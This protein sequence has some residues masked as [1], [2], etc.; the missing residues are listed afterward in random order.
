MSPDQNGQTDTT[1][2]KTAQVQ[3]GQTEKTCSRTEKNKQ[4][5]LAGGVY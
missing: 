1:Q 4:A 5:D 3:I 2:T